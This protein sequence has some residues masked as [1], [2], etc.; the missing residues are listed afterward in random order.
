MSEAI[1]PP[2][3]P[4][5]RRV[6]RRP[7]SSPDVSGSKQ[8]FTAIIGTFFARVKHIQVNRYASSPCL[9]STCNNNQQ[10]NQ[11]HRED[12]KHRENG[13]RRGE[14]DRSAAIPRFIVER[15]VAA[16][17]RRTLPGFVSQ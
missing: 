5:P 12:G 17:S 6:F 11:G 15:H 8:A 14:P 13:Q 3:P 16:L 1:W 7:L 4:A 10:R 2:P 9:I